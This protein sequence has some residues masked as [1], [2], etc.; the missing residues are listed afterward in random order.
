MFTNKSVVEE[1]KLKHRAFTL[2]SV[3]MLT[4]K[5]GTPH[6]WMGVAHSTYSI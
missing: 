3:F 6:N 2:V 4:L 5:I 1:I